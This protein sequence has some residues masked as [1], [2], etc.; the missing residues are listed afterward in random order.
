MHPDDLAYVLTVL[1]ARW[2]ELRQLGPAT[3]DEAGATRKRQAIEAAVGV[4]QA[5]K[6]DPGATSGHDDGATGE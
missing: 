4:L 6:V 1:R 5:A 3:D 2:A